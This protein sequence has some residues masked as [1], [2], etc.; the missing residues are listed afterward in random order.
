MLMYIGSL[1]CRQACFIKK[2]LVTN[3]S[4]ASKQKIQLV[5]RGPQ[6]KWPAPRGTGHRKL[7]NQTKS[8][9]RS[10][11][12]K[13]RARDDPRAVR[14]LLLVEAA[15]ER[16]GPRSNPAHRVGIDG[17][18]GVMRR[19][20]PSALRMPC[21]AGATTGQRASR[22]LASSGSRADVS[23]AAAPNERCAPR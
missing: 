8:E 23:A 14:P 4:R 2:N 9:C 6:C 13:S 7:F 18:R 3:A 17:C 15:D 5:M 1:C 12:R 16:R 20:T 22:R 11:A 10:E 21:S 19:A